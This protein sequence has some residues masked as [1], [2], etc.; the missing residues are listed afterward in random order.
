MNITVKF[1][2]K[3]QD[4]KY[5]NNIMRPEHILTITYNNMF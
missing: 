1:F 2:Q 4:E 5:M 3:A